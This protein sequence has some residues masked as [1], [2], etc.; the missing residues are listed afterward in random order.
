MSKEKLTKND[1]A[2]ENLFSRYPILEEIDKNGFFEIA[3]AQINLERESRLMAKFDFRVNLP[4]VFQTN[5]L[6]ILP[7]SRSKYVIGHFDTH[8]PVKYDGEMEVLPVQISTNIESIDYANLYSESSALL[9]AYNLGIIDDLIGE[10]TQFTVS[11][12]MSSGCFEF[13]VKN[14]ISDRSHSLRVENSQCEIDAGFESNNFFV[15]IEAKKYA[16]EDLLIRQLYY[17]YRL[18]S[19]KLTKKV[20]PVLMTYS[21]DVFSFFIYQFADELDYNSI[22]LVEQKDYAIAPEEIHKSDVWNIFENVRLIAEPNTPFPQADVFERVIDLL[23]LLLE[24]DLTKDEITE[25]YLFDVRQTE[26]YTTAGRYLGLIDKPKDC[27]SLTSEARS[28]FGKTH[29]TKNLALIEKIL[30]RP[31]FY[32]ALK[33]SLN[34][35]IPSLD[36]I[37]QIMSDNGLTI[38]NRTKKR[39]ASTVR[40]WIEWIWK[41]IED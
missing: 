23:S 1:L 30:E 11:G 22:V 38:S 27:F 15:L 24:N 14:S 36:K 40:G 21:N 17:P 20:V 35:K 39:R 5:N 37:C 28:I 33:L 6:S 9:C 13:N 29:K 12:R 32:Q 25:N 19:S 2:W 8:L 26:Y 41:Q 3:A 4:Q 18:W 7:I 34:G 31:V 10:A 16:V